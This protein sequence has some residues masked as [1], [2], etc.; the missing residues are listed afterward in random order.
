VIELES[1]TKK[2]FLDEDT[3]VCPVRDVSLTIEKGDLALIIG[4]SGSGK[5]T[6]LSIAGGLIRPTSGKVFI[7]GVDI[8]GLQEPELST[9]RARKLGFVFQSPSLLPSLSVLENVVL[10]SRFTRASPPGDVR[11]FGRNL[12]EMVGLGARAGSYPH[13]LSSGEHK[14]AVIARALINQ[15]DIL[16]ADEP[17]GDLD[18]GTAQD[19]VDLLKD[20]NNT[21]Q[22]IV[23]VTHNL[24]IVPSTDRVLTMEEGRLVGRSPATEPAEKSSTR[25]GKS[26]YGSTFAQ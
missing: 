2:Y 26:V 19:I 23:M 11:S 25:T 1:V 20:I 5:T 21:G 7:E 3:M 16:L 9:F 4:R 10:P 13:Q 12:L 15:P 24:D 22:T 8:W 17:T 18:R 14:R 6:L